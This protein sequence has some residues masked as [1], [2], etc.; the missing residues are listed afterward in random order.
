MSNA[1]PRVQRR[2][3]CVTT[4]LQDRIRGFLLDAL[5]RIGLIFSH[6]EYYASADRTPLLA[7]TSSHR[8]CSDSIALTC[9]FCFTVDCPHRA[10]PQC[11]LVLEYLYGRNCQKLSY[12]HRPRLA[13]HERASF[14]VGSVRR[15]KYRWGESGT[16]PWPRLS[17]RVTSCQFCVGQGALTV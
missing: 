17:S 13:V 10:V 5:E 11:S 4:E 15:D 16:Y 2:H 14:R 9:P 12:V 7:L 1:F 8:I 3:K 6:H